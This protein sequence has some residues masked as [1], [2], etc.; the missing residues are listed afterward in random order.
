MKSQ[1]FLLSLVAVLMASCSGMGGSANYETAKDSVCYVLGANMGKQMSE[2]QDRFP[3][4]GMNMDEFTAGFIAGIDSVDSK[5]KDLET[6]TFLQGYFTNA[7]TKEQEQAAA[8]AQDSTLEAYQSPA[9]DTASY[10]YG[11]LFGS[12]RFRSGAEQFPGGPMNIEAVK[13]GLKDF[14]AE[15]ELSI[16][17]EDEESFLNDYF[18][19]AEET[20]RAEAEAKAKAELG[21]KLAEIDKFMEENGSRPGVITHE[22]GKFQYEVMK[23]G[24]GAKPVATDQV[25]VHYHGTF[26]DGSVFDSSVERGEPATFGLNQVIQGWTEGLQLMPV[27]SKYKFYIHPE[28][29]YGMQANRGIPA[30]SLL[31]FEVE[32]LEIV[33]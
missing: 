33:K 14:M 11:Y 32:L 30:A 2:T 12:D 29:A 8:M 25:K 5:Y 10:V 13:A 20:A 31:I 23:E 21:P 15:K 19:K 7:Q 27:G 1:L 24:N 9:K 4:G 18:Q 3:G 28:Y 16:V 26:L 6:Q 17:V 22:S